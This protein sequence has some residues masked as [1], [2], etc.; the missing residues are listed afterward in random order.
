MAGKKRGMTLGTTM[1]VMSL[2]STL[3]FAMAGGLVS[4][5]NM[6]KGALNR[7]RA[8]S[9]AESAVACAIEGIQSESSFGTSADGTVLQVG[10]GTEVGYSTFDPDKAAQLGLDRSVNNLSQPE[11]VQGSRNT[12]VPPFTAHLVGVGK[13]GGVTERV[14]VMLRMPTLPALVTEGKVESSGGLMV[15]AVTRFDQVGPL[16][17]GTRPVRVPADLACN[18]KAKDSITLAK[19]TV[20]SGDIQSVGGISYPQDD[21]VKILGEIRTSANPFPLP[22]LEPTQYDPVSG[23]LPYTTMTWQPEPNPVLSGR[24]RV[25]GGLTVTGDLNLDSCVLFVN[26]PVTIT[27]ALKG[28]GALV[29]T[30]SVKID[31]GATLDAGQRVS[32]LA[33][34]DIE[35]TGEDRKNSFIQ[36]LVYTKGKLTARRLT[37]VGA[38]VARGGATLDTANLIYLPGS[39]H[40][41]MD[42][43]LTLQFSAKAGEEDAKTFKWTAQIRQVPEGTTMEFVIDNG[44]MPLYTQDGK[45]ATK[46][47]EVLYEMVYMQNGTEKHVQVCDETQINEVMQDFF[48]ANGSASSADRAGQLWMDFS[49]GESIHCAEGDMSNVGSAGSEMGSDGYTRVLNTTKQQKEKFGDVPVG[50]NLDPNKLMRWEDRLRIASWR[51]VP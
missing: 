12:S 41:N 40:L 6:T 37:V 4:Q 31:H 47:M 51:R 30:G 13:C 11:A 49:S 3:A 28:R 44:G 32:L 25:P 50:F 5:L 43:P 39:D 23:T 29:S 2:L 19:D 8:M 22:H 38:A 42:D 24:I 9:L 21:S 48:S 27:G 16:V 18:S 35:I 46:T 34:G 33:E 1:I 45:R 10:S 26:G 14:E 17:D 20:V 7:E 36:G 15:A